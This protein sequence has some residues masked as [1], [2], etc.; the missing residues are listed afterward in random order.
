M[1]VI[2]AVPCVTFCSQ[3][4]Q[5]PFS[6]RGE[7]NCACWVGWEL[8][9]NKSKWH[10]FPSRGFRWRGLRMAKLLI[11]G[12]WCYNAAMTHED[13]MTQEICTP[14]SKICHKGAYGDTLRHQPRPGLV[15]SSYLTPKEHLLKEN[16][17]PLL[18]FFYHTTFY[19]TCRFN[20]VR[21]FRTQS[22]ELN[23][24][25]LILLN[26]PDILYCP[27]SENGNREL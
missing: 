23:L 25:L 1:K 9:S 14:L 27:H 18:G 17:E 7:Q 8:K 11:T 2:M 21:K 3:I 4:D 15:P 20:P 16:L 5:C 10:H 24:L 13:Q 12:P 26:E 6:W 22:S 19:T